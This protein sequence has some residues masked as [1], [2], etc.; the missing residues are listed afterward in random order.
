MPVPKPRSGEKQDAFIG[1]CM[2][3]MA[4]ES[5]RPRDQQLA[6]CF[7]TWR[8]HKRGTE[9]SDQTKKYFEIARKVVG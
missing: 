7:G 9:D 8:R 1:R 3:F 5:G 4:G 6:I 2:K